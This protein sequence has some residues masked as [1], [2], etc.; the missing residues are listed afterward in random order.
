MAFALLSILRVRCSPS[1][2]LEGDTTFS[3]DRD[4]A[5]PM[6]VL[7]G[8]RRLGSANDGYRR[9]GDVCCVLCQGPFIEPKAAAQS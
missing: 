9:V 4:A 2:W 7:S 6:A 5:E 8:H 3:F 1:N